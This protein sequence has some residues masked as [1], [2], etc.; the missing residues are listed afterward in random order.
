MLGK[1][2]ILLSDEDV[3]IELA[4]EPCVMIVPRLGGLLRS[5]IDIPPLIEPP[6]VSSTGD[7]DNE[8]LVG[9]ADVTDNSGTGS[10]G[11]FKFIKGLDAVSTF[12]VFTVEPISEISNSRR[13]EGDPD[14]PP[15]PFVLILVILACLECLTVV[16]ALLRSICWAKLGWEVTRETVADIGIVGIGATSSL[17]GP[18]VDSWPMDDDPLALPVNIGLNI[19]GVSGNSCDTILLSPSKPSSVDGV[20]GS[21]RDVTV[22]L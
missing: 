6:G 9:S 3:Y 2:F 22:I 13:F 19:S 20:S 11:A 16:P 1:D 21:V 8:S 5:T 15:T 14:L 4:S 17:P 7:C 18:S 12:A 10:C